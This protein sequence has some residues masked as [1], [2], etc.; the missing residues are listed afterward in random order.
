MPSDSGLSKIAQHFGKEEAVAVFRQAA[1]TEEA[2][3]C[4]GSIKLYRRAFK[5]WDALDSG[6]DDGGLPRAVRHAA[7]A[8]GIDCDA[9]ADALLVTD[10]TPRF[11]VS[12]SSE[13]L[14]YLEEH[15]YC[16][17]ADVADEE[18]VTL[19]KS[20][21]WNYLESIPDT[22][23][24]RDDISTWEDEDWV[25][26]THNGVFG[27]HGFGQ[28]AFCWHTRLL[29]GV[30]QA[31]T[32]IWDCCD[33]L[34]SFDGGNV[35]RPWAQKEQW[36]T[37]GGWWHVDQNVFLPGK[38]DRSSV[39]GLVTYIDATPETGGLCVIP[40]SHKH[41]ISVCERSCA[42]TVRKD[43]VQVQ[44]GDPVLESGGQLVCA[45]AGDL[46][47]WDSRCVHCNTPGVVNTREAQGEPGD[48]NNGIQQLGAATED[49]GSMS[50]AEPSVQAC[51]NSELLRVAGYV[52]MTPAAWACN[53]VLAKRK[54]AFIDNETI[55]HWPHEYHGPCEKLS[56]P[57]SNT[58][59]DASELQ[60]QMV[61]GALSSLRG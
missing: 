7:E 11:A 59:S 24:R 27:S 1:A 16:V 21:M 10:A 33:L 13:W 5:M 30:R 42:Q 39:Q 46:I 45:K 32:A 54:D 53:D 52:C 48:S 8:A 4:E 37:H 26:S 36:R 25:P 9:L 56:W 31:F 12:A 50:T 41:H 47:L 43:C 3:D 19:A 23:V 55:D 29:P 34:V 35:F 20:L 44:P 51:T 17:L 2:G 60:R 38:S 49:T 22:K 58:W 15:G 28:S 14:P 40:G 6:F 57:P 18:E 61:V